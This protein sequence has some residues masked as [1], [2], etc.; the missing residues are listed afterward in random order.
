MNA[1]SEPLLILNQAH[2]PL[3]ADLVQALT[4]AGE[5]CAVFTGSDWPRKG[6]FPPEARILNAPTL[7]RKSTSTRFFSWLA[8]S[9]AAT[10]LL[11]RC[12]SDARVLV[13]SNP[14]V[15]P[16]VV[17]F[18]SL[19]RRFR[20]SVMIYDIY[21]DVLAGLGLASD[22]HPVSRIWRYIHRL[23]FS[24]AFAVMTV[25]D[26]M[27]KVLERQFDPAVTGA[28]A[29]VV[30]RPWVNTG[31]IRPRVKE[32]NPFAV[33][34]G[35]MGRITA[36]YSGNLGATH[37]T[38]TIIGAARQMGTDSGVSFLF[39]GSGPGARAL[40]SAA[41]DLANVTLLPWQPEDQVPDM[42]ACAEIAFIALR[43]GTERCSFP[44]RTAF[45]LS[46]GCAI[47]AITRTPSDVADIVSGRE[48]GI[49]IS[50]G[51]SAG[52]ARALTCLA[53]DAELLRRYRSNARRAAEALFGQ[54]A[55]IAA[56]MRGV[57][58]PVRSS[59]KQS[60]PPQGTPGLSA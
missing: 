29:I 26:V 59:P 34:N 31:K 13:F 25:G 48:C 1:C 18:C 10:A 17:W 57:P 16:F 39:I 15:L 36:L 6:T 12:G 4:D 19:F 27:A 45:A 55:N 7:D 5:D 30:S 60:R 42:W 2:G 50:P 20:Y 54:E 9:L 11:L 52:L 49:V 56:L 14:P 44:S 40:E 22:D 35:Q 51:D 8:Y 38:D 47:V 41:G 28:G 23:S 58:A 32:D 43:P 53:G 37:D 21:P 46:A 33:G 3:L 24:R